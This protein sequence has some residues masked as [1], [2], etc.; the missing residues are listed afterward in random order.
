MENVLILGRKFFVLALGF[1]SGSPRRQNS[2]PREGFCSNEGA[3]LE[4]VR[5]S[6][7]PTRGECSRWA[8]GR[9]LV[10]VGLL[11]DLDYLL[12]EEEQEKEVSY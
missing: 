6:I 8:L 7:A 10:V 9:R 3:S 2:P 1:S 11:Q 12:G 4:V 5:N